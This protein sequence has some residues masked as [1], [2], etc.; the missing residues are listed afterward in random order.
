MRRSE[1]ANVLSGVALIC[2][3]RRDRPS[4]RSYR[5]RPRLPQVA[6]RDDHG[7]AAELPLSGDPVGS[8]R[9][10]NGWSRRL[11]DAY[12]FARLNSSARPFLLRIARVLD[13]QP[14]DACVVG[15]RETLR[16][17]TFEV[18]RAHQLEQFA[19]PACDGQRL[20]NDRQ[21]L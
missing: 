14:P 20:E 11:P 2:G 10:A 8:A 21:T 7:S 18:V 16:Y 15:I 5:D 9:P 17:D 6:D 1:S 12:A 13:L 4:G 19:P 3:P